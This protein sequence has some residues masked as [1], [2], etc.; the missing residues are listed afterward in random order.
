MNKKIKLNRIFGGIIYAVQKYNQRKRLSFSTFKKKVHEAEQKAA[1][2]NKRYRIYSFGGKFHAV[3]KEDINF[4]KN[5]KYLSSKVDV[6]VV[7]KYCLYDTLTHS[8]LHPSFR[9][10]DLDIEQ[11]KIKKTE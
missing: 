2:E 10:M 9:E 11:Y 6:G 3:N 8:N 5:R 1:L 4:L 7:D